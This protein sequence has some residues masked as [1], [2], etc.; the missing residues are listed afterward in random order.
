MKALLIA[1]FGIISYAVGMG[2]LVYFILYLG[3]WDF[4]PLHINSA[5]SGDLTLAIIV[6][7]SLMVLFGLHHSVAA[8][9]AFK[10]Q[11]TR[12][13]P[14]SA[15]R[16]T[17]V[18]MS[19][20]LLLVIC[21]YWQ[22]IEGVLW[23]VQSESLAMV[24]TA[25][26]LTGWVIVVISSFLINHFELFGLGQVY[27]NLRSLPEPEDSFVEFSF[28]KL[29]R[30]PLQLGVLIGIW[31]TPFMTMTHLMLAT[32][33]TIYIFIGL[34]YEEKDLV[35]ALGPDYESY[36]KRVRKILPIPTSGVSERPLK[37]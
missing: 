19:G 16:S 35:A 6:N 22:P 29:V 17:Y 9:P 36:Q 23:Q 31:C 12:I 30:H 15:E 32:T 18:L 4:L 34:Y 10:K 28:Y 21:Y 3:S 20:V 5:S 24:L 37:L 26:Y 11:L 1:L 13:V 2:G 14:E 25:G 7:L 8:R 27:R 33:L